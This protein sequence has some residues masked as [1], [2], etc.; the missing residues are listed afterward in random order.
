[1]DLENV[2]ERLAS[3]I[4]W[5]DADYNRT[6]EILNIYIQNVGT[7][8]IP[9]DNSSTDPTTTWI[10]KD[11]NNQKVIYKVC[12]NCLLHLTTFSLCPNEFKNLLKNGHTIEEILLNDTFYNENGE[13]L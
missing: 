12:P 6:T 9:V 4:N 7:T 3:T 1:M 8:D 13:S 10:L 11:S 2:C 5:E